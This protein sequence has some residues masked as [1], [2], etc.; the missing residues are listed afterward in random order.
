MLADHQR[1]TEAAQSF[2]TTPYPQGI[3]ACGNDIAEQAAIRFIRSELLAVLA[4][5]EGRPQDALDEL[6]APNISRD[7]LITH[8]LVPGLRWA[9]I[10]ATA[11]CALESQHLS[12]VALRRSSRARIDVNISPY[13]SE[14][15]YPIDSQVVAEVCQALDS[16]HRRL[17]SSLPSGEGG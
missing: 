4:L 7:G 10:D 6:I 13:S 2:H 9:L 15:Y 1:A 3:V 16:Q 11:A 17:E 8:R 12:Q 5:T 14:F